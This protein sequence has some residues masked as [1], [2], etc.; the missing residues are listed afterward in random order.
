MKIDI[1][2]AGRSLHHVGM[3]R[4]VAISKVQVA[5]IFSVKAL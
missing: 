3:E 5:S 2:Y 1:D 4:A